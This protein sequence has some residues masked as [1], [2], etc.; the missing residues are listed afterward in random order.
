[1][2]CSGRESQV[3]SGLGIYIQKLKAVHSSQAE[4]DLMKADGDALCGRKQ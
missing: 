2:G 3:W 4:E 1:M